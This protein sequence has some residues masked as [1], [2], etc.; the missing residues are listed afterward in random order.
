MFLKFREQAVWEDATRAEEEGQ[1]PKTK[2]P[3]K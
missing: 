2:F 3:S 1:T